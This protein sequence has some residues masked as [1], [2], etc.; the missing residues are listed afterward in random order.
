MLCDICQGIFSCPRKLSYGTYYP[1]GHT[2]RTFV[3]A[4]QGGCHL[5]D[6]VWYNV[7]YNLGTHDPRYSDEFPN[8]CTYAFKV[9]NPEWARRGK[10]PKW[11]VPASGRGDDEF[12]EVSRYKVAIE[13]D[14]TNNQLSSLLAADSEEIFSI[15]T[16]FWLV[17]DFYCPGPRIILPLEIVRG[18][19]ADLL[20]L[21]LVH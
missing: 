8:R 21:I 2:N 18:K 15:S 7:S 3:A 16:D 9:L 14:P 11:L 20:D 6:L 17:L 4:R 10:G 12:T 19:G 5:C 1:W 13:N